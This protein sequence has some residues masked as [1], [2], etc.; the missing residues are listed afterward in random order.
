MALPT[1]PATP[2]Q[3]PESYD[4]SRLSPAVRDALK[5]HDPEIAR[6]VKRVADEPATPNK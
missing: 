5:G 2:Q 1:P 3:T 4:N 6:G